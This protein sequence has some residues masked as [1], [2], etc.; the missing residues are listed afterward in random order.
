MYIRH[1][2]HRSGAPWG[3]HGREGGKNFRGQ[4][5]KF[6]FWEKGPKGGPIR[7][8]MGAPMG[9]PYGPHGAP[10]G[11]PKIYFIKKKNY[12]TILF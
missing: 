10:W 2:D 5:A 7:G 11:G 3:P 9:A 6:F 12:N 4:A 1:I 8:P